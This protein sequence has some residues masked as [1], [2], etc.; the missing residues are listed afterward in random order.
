M[1]QILMFLLMSFACC[2]AFPQ[3]VNN[4]DSVT[5]TNERLLEEVVVTANIAPYKLSKGGMVIRVNG[6]P[7]SDVGTCFDVLSQMPGV[8]VNDE[9][10]EVIGKGNPQIYINGRRMLDR[11]ELQR[12]SS[13]D[14]QNVE[15][16][17][18]PG[19]K[20][21]AEI[22]SVILIKTVKKQGDGLSGSF[23]ATGRQAHSFSQADNI[24]L[25]YR[26]GG[27]DVFGSFNFDHARRFQEQ[28]NHTSIKTITDNYLL[29]ADIR[30]RPV[31]INLVGNVGANWQINKNHSI[32]IKYEYAA[33][34]YSKSNW[35]TDEDIFLNDLNAEHIMFDT[36][37]NR[38]SL[39]TNSVNLYYFG[40]VKSFTINIAN[41][42]YSQRN[43]ST[44]TIYEES[45]LPGNNTLGSKNTIRNRLWASK[46]T[47]TYGFGGNEIEFGY[48]FTSTDRKDLFENINDDL[49]DAN[50][51]IKESNIAGFVSINIPVNRVEFYA[52]LRFERTV[53]DYYMYSSYIP[54]QSRKYNRLYPSFDF[55][56]PIKKANFTLS[57]TSKVKRPL[58]SQLSS[59][60]QYDDR[61]TYETGN[62]Y[63]TSE[64][65][66]DISLAGVWKWIFFSMG[67]QYDKDAIM[68]VIKP[69]ENGSPVNLM[70][71]DN[72]SHITKYNIVLS[73]S[74][75]IKRWSPRVR[76]N[77]IGQNFDIQTMDGK[78]NMNTPILFWNVYNTINLGKEFNLSADLTGRTK[79][80]MDVVTLKPSWQF[81]IGLTKNIKGWYFQLQ[82]TDVFKT[83]RNSM[84]TYGEQ[85]TLDKWNYSDTQAIRLIV[86]YS[87]NATVNKYKGKSAGTT[88]RNRLL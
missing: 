86:R 6:T 15:V 21:G 4:A 1:K 67:W 69:Y 5:K 40:K 70:S 81:N 42:F 52:G 17:S 32:G 68:S 16:L 61:F 50:D 34:P 31:N 38:R 74:P 55:S 9:N 48:E 51:H 65:I 8:R 22:Q 14:I 66:H 43:N 88:E 84:I 23:Q 75:K 62:P 10:I 39:P 18:N 78:R 36:R 80:D 60:I 63:L 26:T 19:A 33:T 7:L 35:H 47:A 27:I 3:S 79:G 28:R 57:Y 85:M 82:A 2:L 11:S 59:A 77:L 20:Y 13:K 64:M 41:D 87:F 29:N 37:W 58:Y 24:S 73:L 25:N 49:S 56:F 83:A 71:Y 45:N 53:S 46:G 12:I 76:L 54:E 44:Q 72:F 30:I